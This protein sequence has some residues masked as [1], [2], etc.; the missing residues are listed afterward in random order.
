MP[1]NVLQ[2][3]IDIHPHCLHSGACAIPQMA[4]TPIRFP[5]IDAIATQVTSNGRAGTPKFVVG[6]MIV[7]HRNFAPSIHLF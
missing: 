3:F 7:H 4:Q 1:F 2:T 5:F 6:S